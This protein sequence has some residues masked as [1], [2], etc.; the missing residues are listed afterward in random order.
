MTP[1]IHG[2]LSASYGSSLSNDF[3]G[4]AKRVY[5]RNWTDHSNDTSRIH[6]YSPIATYAVYP[7]NGTNS[8]PPSI[9]LPHY[10]FAY[11][12]F[13]PTASV[14]SL[15][16]TIAKSSGI[17]TAVFRKSGSAI[18]EIA[19]NAAGNAYTDTA[20]SSSTELVLL[21][22]NSSG[23]DGENANFSTDG[24]LTSVVEPTPPAPSTSTGNGCFIATAAYGS[25]LHPQVQLLRN[26]RD[27]YLLTNAPGRAFVALYYRFSPPLADVIAR[28]PV[29][30]GMTRLLLTP[31]VVAVAHPFISIVSL[32][33]LIGTLLISRLRRIKA[34]RSNAQSHVICSISRMQ[35][36][37]HDNHF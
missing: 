9:T 10:S 30:R 14:P 2:V 20:F 24:L 27:D 35:E 1:V 18:T 19:V 8:Q 16:I 12:K 22:A 32:F 11:Y 15:T 13:T 17:Q 26:F 28:H 23:T 33:L 4:F 29:L 25:Y 3:F 21:I 34:V 31:L 7:V 37:P 36:R 5:N 6:V